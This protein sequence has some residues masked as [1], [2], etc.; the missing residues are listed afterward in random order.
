MKRMFSVAESNAPT[1]AP[2]LVLRELKEIPRD[3]RRK[4]RQQAEAANEGSTIKTSRT[5]VSRV[6]LRLF[7]LTSGAGIAGWNFYLEESVRATVRETVHSTFLGTAY[8]WLVV[9]IKEICRPF[10]EPSRDKLLPDWPMPGYGIPEGF[11]PLPT[12]VLAVEDVLLHSEWD[13]LAPMNRDIKRIILID[14]KPENFQLQPENA[15]CIPPYTDGQDRSDRQLKDLIPFLV[16]VAEGK[17]QDVP[18]VLADFRDSDG[19]VRDVPSKYNAKVHALDERKRQAEARGL[20]GFVRGRLHSSRA[21]TATAL[22]P[23][24]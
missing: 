19:V 3:M 24:K 22:K 6:A 23:L 2:K 4:L 9:Q 15:I 18:K 10:T 11:P 1:D 8:D 13:D 21:P 14:T 7:L 12:L 20:G 5:P 17:V 16:A